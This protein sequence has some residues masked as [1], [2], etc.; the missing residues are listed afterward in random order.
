[1]KVRQKK[2]AEAN[3]RFTTYGYDLNSNVD[4]R[5]DDGE[6][7]EGGALVKAGRRHRFDYD[8]GDRMRTQEDFGVNGD[9][10]ADDQRITNLF[11]PTGWQTQRKI[12]AN[13]GSGVWSVLQTTNWTHFANGK[14]KT[15][16]T[17]N[18]ANTVI[19]SHTVGYDDPA[20]RYVNGNRTT[21]AFTLRGPESTAPCYS[22]TCTTAFTYDARERLTKQE[23]KNSAG[24]VLNSTTYVINDAGSIEEEAFLRGGVTTKRNMAYLGDRLNTVSEGGKTQNHFYDPA[25]NLDCITTSAGTLA[26][27][28]TA[29][30]LAISPKLL[31]DYGYDYLDRLESYRSFTTDGTTSTPD[32]TAAYTYDALDRTVEE[33]E[34]HGT[35]PAKTTLFSYLGLTNQE[36]EEKQKETAT[37]A[38]N[39]TKSLG[40]DA[41]GV[42]TSMTTTPATGTATTDTFVHDVHGSVSLL[43]SAAGTTKG[44]ARAAYGYKPYGEADPDLTKGDLNND[45][46]IN[47]FR[48]TA[49]RL[50]SGSGSLDM[51]AR[52]F[53]PTT[54]RFLQGDKYHD[55]LADLDLSFD[56]LTQNRY[57]L[58]GGN[59]ISF[60]EVDGHRV[61]PDGSG[62]GWSG[63]TPKQDAAVRTSVTRRSG[64]NR[65]PAARSGACQSCADVASG[66]LNAIS[67]GQGKRIEGALGLDSNVDYDSN[68]RGWGEGVGAVLDLALGGKGLVKKAPQA[69]SRI[70]KGLGLRRAAPST[71]TP[72]AARVLRNKAIGDEAADAIASRYP[73]ARREVTLQAESGVR[74]LDVLTPQ[75]LAI[76]SKVGHTS[77]T[78]AT[79]RELARDVELLNDPSSGVRAVEWHFVRSP[80]T[81][82]HGPTAPLL[83]A[84]QKAGIRVVM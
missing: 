39:W 58:A 61:I 52:R 55:A 7:T 69:L 80:T 28:N 65:L 76:E 30:G 62:T 83:E 79:R 10:A 37:G 59:P 81:G 43:V 1:M 48:Y 78:A 57:S 54:T 29:T 34:S 19:E 31:A 12:E 60:I 40:Y 9:S 84:L 46:P 20:G 42:R 49:K 74:R 44:T 71:D 5:Q 16:S 70:P 27:C 24:S 63:P 26:D 2:K 73:G 77:L 18:G 53:G 75:G 17:T 25:G 68:P 45:D 4:N 41:A 23:L 15:L 50:D 36:V 32:D 33:V 51:G 66:V 72:Q 11:A 82:K 8:E 13:N 22:T 14:L 67:F 6:E 35:T 64:L 47:P 21:D 56:P 3:Y 38:A